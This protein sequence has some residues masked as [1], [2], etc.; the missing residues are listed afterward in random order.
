MVLN[1]VEFNMDVRQAVDAPRMHDQWL[2]DHVRVEPAHGDA[3]RAARSTTL[4]GMGH[5]LSQPRR[6]GDAHSIWIDPATGE[7]VAAADQ[8]ISGSAAGY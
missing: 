6:Q 7:I 3:T 5:R 2:P 4:R 1:V 8:R